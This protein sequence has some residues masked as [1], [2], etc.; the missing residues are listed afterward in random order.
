MSSIMLGTIDKTSIPE[1]FKLTSRFFPSKVGGKPAWLDLKHIPVASELACSKCNIPLVFLCQLYA[2]IDDPEFRGTCFHRT[3][4]VF[5]CNEC[6][7]RQ[8]FVVLRSQLGIKN[9]F[10][11]DDPAEP[12]DPDITPDMWGI[13]LCKVRIH[14]KLMCKFMVF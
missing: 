5:Y 13:K 9:D 3:L 11:S 14:K 4:Y 6:R 7:S 12:D 1:P 10:Y 2:P 8:S